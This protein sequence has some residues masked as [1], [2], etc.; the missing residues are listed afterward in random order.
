MDFFLYKF[1]A[2]IPRLLIS[3]NQIFFDSKAGKFKPAQHDSTFNF[4]N[5]GSYADQSS[6]KEAYTDVLHWCSILHFDCAKYYRSLNQMTKFS[7]TALKAHYFTAS[8][9]SFSC[10]AFLRLERHDIGYVHHYPLAFKPDF[11]VETK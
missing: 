9:L 6:C 5:F 11:Y 4:V 3:L 10:P 8:D 7:E 2:Q 1:T